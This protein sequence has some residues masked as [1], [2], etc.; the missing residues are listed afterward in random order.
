MDLSDNQK[1]Q[2]GFNPYNQIRP[3]QSFAPTYGA[4]PP[5][6]S[7][8]TQGFNPHQLMGAFKMLMGA[9]QQLSMG[10]QSFGGNHFGMQG[11]YGAQQVYGANPIAF[12]Q[13]SFGYNGPI[14]PNPNP[15]SLLPA[16]QTSAPSTYSPFQVS[17]VAQVQARPAYFG[18]PISPNPN[19]YSLLPA[20]QYS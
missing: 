1:M 18:G 2:A 14:S 9:M 13:P 16:G 20:G 6:Y 5:Q 8:P 15:Y 3:Q 11:Q 19:P 12:P 4:Y 17:N 10:W 7:A